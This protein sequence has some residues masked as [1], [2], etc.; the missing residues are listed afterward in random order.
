MCRMLPSRLVGSSYPLRGHA[1]GFITVSFRRTFHSRQV[2][3]LRVPS[4]SRTGRRIKCTHRGAPQMLHI[5]GSS[6][7]TLR[8]APQLKIDQFQYLHRTLS[9]QA[10]SPH[11]PPT[12]LSLVWH[13]TTFA[14][15]AE[16]PSAAFTSSS[17][18]SRATRE[19]GRSGARCV[20][21]TSSVRP[22]SAFTTG[23]TQAR[24]RT[25]ADSVG[26]GSHS[27]AVWGST[28]AHTVGNGPTAARCAGRPLF[29]CTI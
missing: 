13:V 5:W 6:T 19:S 12:S 29:W 23:H 9:R 15:S 11:T 25:V 17:C 22:T 21:R 18:T 3:N 14:R 2:F 26:R 28:S 27:R 7:N 20:E 1:M 10:A 8:G 4:R 16:R 24:S